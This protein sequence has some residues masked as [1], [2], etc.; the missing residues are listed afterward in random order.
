MACLFQDQN[1]GIRNDKPRAKR[2]ESADPSSWRKRALA[3]LGLNHP[4]RRWG[5]SPRP[6][7]IGLAGMAKPVPK[8]DQ[9]KAAGQALGPSRISIRPCRAGISPVCGAKIRFQKVNA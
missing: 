7:N 9:P 3:G 1:Q 4:Y 8:Y 6:E 2:T 5:I